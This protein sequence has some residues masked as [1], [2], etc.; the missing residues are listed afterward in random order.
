MR[1]DTR[2]QDFPRAVKEL[3]A[4]RDSFDG[5]PCCVFCGRA[6]PGGV[7]WSNAHYIPRSHGGLGVVENGLTLCPSCHARYDQTTE[8]PFMRLFFRD[9][10]MEKHPGWSEENLTYRK[11]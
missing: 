3:I 1:K 7:A 10:L 8:R 5:W 4:D 11:E 9:Y 6:A 2:A